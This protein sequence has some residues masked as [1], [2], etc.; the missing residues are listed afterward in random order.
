MMGPEVWEAVGLSVFRKRESW[1]GVMKSR[2]LNWRFLGC[3]NSCSVGLGGKGVPGGIGEVGEGWEPVCNKHHPLFRHQKSCSVRILL[4]RNQLLLVL[5]SYHVWMYVPQG[6]LCWEVQCLR[7][8]A[9][10]VGNWRCALVRDYGSPA[11][12]FSVYPLAGDTR[13]LPL[14]HDVLP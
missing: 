12:S 11:H 6:S 13:C 2:L 5:S 10:S 8:A 4:C 1:P 3:S 7:R 9:L 14:Y